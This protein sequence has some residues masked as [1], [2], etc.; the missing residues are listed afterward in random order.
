[1]A[2]PSCRGVPGEVLYRA[3]ANEVAV[4]GSE[5][6]DVRDLDHLGGHLIGGSSVCSI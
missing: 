3:G 6:R 5:E 1:V 4:L 2:G